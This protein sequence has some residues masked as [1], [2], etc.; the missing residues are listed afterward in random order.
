M[1]LLDNLDSD[2]ANE[3]TICFEALS[4]G[5]VSDLVNHEPRSSVFVAS[6]KECKEG[7]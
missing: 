6:V 2:V 7:T 3:L 4:D 1:V 5:C